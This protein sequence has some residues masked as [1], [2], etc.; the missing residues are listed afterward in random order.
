MKF[1]DALQL[2]PGTLKKYISEV[3]S[4][5]EKRYYI[6]AL[7]IRDILLVTFAIIFISIL[8]NLFGSENSSMAVVIFCVLLS[9]RFVDFGYKIKDSIIALAIVFFILLV[10]PVIIQRV[11]PILGLL[12]NFISLFIILL[13]TCEKPKM[14]NGGLFVF[15][16]VFL[17]GNLVTSEIFFKRMEMTISGFII[18]A[19]VMY[20]KHNNKHKERKFIHILNEFNIDNEKYQWQLQI[21]LAI[22]LLFFIGSFFDFDRFIW[23]G[24]ACS[25]LLSS[26][27]I[28]IHDRLINRAIGATIGSLLFG[29]VYYITPSSMTFLFGPISGLCI[30]LCTSYFYKT[31]FNCFGAL[32]MASSIYGVHDS[33]ILRI[34]N[35][36]IGLLF[37]YI[38]FHIFQMLFVKFYLKRNKHQY[39]L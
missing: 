19:I 30:G 13:L 11:N 15:G 32:M 1:Y 8:T 17:S 14:G 7:I 3:S 6:K 12:I 36:L 37:G 35:N 23:I 31:I 5:K 33:I 20:F 34:E 22:S 24:F 29:I 16:Y 2:D 28:N 18:C 27:P 39:N 26:Y 21:A 9:I 38:F 4:K 10:A 25:S